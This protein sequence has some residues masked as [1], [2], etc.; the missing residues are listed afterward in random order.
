MVR[1]V[2]VNK[3]RNFSYLHSNN[4]FYIGIIMGVGCNLVIYKNLK[5]AIKRAIKVRGYV[6]EVENGQELS[7]GKIIEI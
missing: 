2:I 5:S 4:C 6:L 7:E 1:Y 3:K